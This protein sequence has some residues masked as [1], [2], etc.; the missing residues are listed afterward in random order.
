[1]RDRD[2]ALGAYIGAAIGD[3]MGGP[4]EC[5]HAARIK[6]LASEIDGGKH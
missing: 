5:N 1:M 4:V 6:R 2:K 3:A